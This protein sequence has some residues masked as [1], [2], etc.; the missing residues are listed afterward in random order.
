MTEELTTNDSHKVFVYGTLK[1]NEP[2]HE[3]FCD[4]KGYYQFLAKGH[5]KEKYPLV[6]ASKYNIPFLLDR[7][8]TGHVIKRLQFF[9]LIGFRNLCEIYRMSAAKFTK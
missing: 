2:N 4:F 9:V 8:N 3:V 1:G 6:I 5:T 7:A